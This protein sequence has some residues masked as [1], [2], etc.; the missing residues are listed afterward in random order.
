MEKKTEFLRLVMSKSVRQNVEKLQKVYGYGDPAK[1]ISLAL[2]LL[3]SVTIETPPDTDI[4]LHFS[5][6]T[7]R[8]VTLPPRAEINEQVATKKLQHTCL[9][10]VPVPHFCVACKYEEEGKT[11]P[12]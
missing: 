3:D 5:D 7:Q 6:G 9:P 12:F 4:F 8:Q 11:C 2:A 1:V 10:G